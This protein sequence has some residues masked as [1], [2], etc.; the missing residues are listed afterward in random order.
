M[1]VSAKKGRSAK[2]NAAKLAMRAIPDA[3]S[4][5]PDGTLVN[6]L[7]AGA[8]VIT[9]ARS[10]QDLCHPTIICVGQHELKIGYERRD[11]RRWS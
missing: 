4:S 10:H 9:G 6:E 2:P 8:L 11:D 3:R 1:T 7:P 5:V